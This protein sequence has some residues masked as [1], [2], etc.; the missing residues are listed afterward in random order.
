[1][2][3]NNVSAV[4]SSGELDFGANS[5]LAGFRL[6]RL[7]VLNWGTFDKRVWAFRPDGKNA[8]LTGDI[9]SGKSTLV[10]AV[11]T[12]LV[13]AQRIAYNKAAGADAK[14]RTLRSYVLGYYK[15]ER[16][17]VS[18]NAKPVALRD[19]RSF[20]VI[21]GIFHN[22][23]FDKTV[24]LAQVFWCREPT[25]QPERFYAVAETPLAIADDF[26]H[27]GSSIE[28]LK[29]RLKKAGVALFDS[30]P[31]YSAL[32]RRLLGGLSEQALELFLQT[33]SMKSVGNLTDFVRQHMLEPFDVAPRV[34]ALIAHFDD[35]NRAHAAVL[36][37]QQQVAL[38]TPLVA[39]CDQHAAVL[40][41]ADELRACRDGLRAY[42]S[43]Q[44]LGLIAQRLI[45]LTE[46]LAR[47]SA[48]VSK[49]EDQREQE[50]LQERDLRQALATNGGDRLALLARDI[51]Q[52][53]QEVTR[54]R[55]SAARYDELRRELGLL[56][57]ASTE[58]LVAQQQTCTQMRA[59][60]TAQLDA[61]QNSL[62]ERSVELSEGRRAH[63][64]LSDEITSLK[65]RRSNTDA[66]AVRMRA[67]LCAAL[68][69]DEDSMPFAGEL[70]EVRE[71]QRDWEGAVERL[72]H[73]FGLS[74]LVP[75]ALYAQVA[76]W[77]DQTHLK[78]RLVYFRVR[79]DVRAQAPSLHADS[80]V[81]K[82]VVKPDSPFYAWL[83]REL[84][85]RFDVACCTTQE[86]FRRELRAISRAGQIKSGGERHEKD[87]RHRLDDRSRYVLGWSNTAKLAALNAKRK[88]LE[89]QLAQLGSQIAQ[90]Q[91]Q[92]AQ[93]QERL[94]LLAKLVEYRDYRE[95]D[96][97]T[98][99]AQ[100]AALAQERQ[101]IEAAS[102][103][104][105][106]LTAQL[107]ALEEAQLQTERLSREQRDKR[108][109]VE[110]KI[111][112][113]QALQQQTLETLK[114]E[115]AGA[116]QP[117]LA[118]VEL[119]SP[120]NRRLAQLQADILGAASITLE[121][122]DNRQ[123]D[124]RE[125]LQKLIAAEE[126]KASSLVEKIVDAMRSFRHR[127]PLATQEADASVAASGEFRALLKQLKVDDL[128]RFEAKFKDLLNQNT[129]NQVAQFSA[130][131]AK[132]RET[133]KERLTLINQSL[134]Q[135]DYNPGRFIELQAQLTP[136]AEV[137]DFQSDLRH[138]LDGAI[139]GSAA[140][141]D[142][143]YSE[144]KFLQVKAIIER[145][146]G[147]EGQTD[148]DKR[149]TQ[150]VTD[151]RNWF[152]FAA[153]ERWREDGREHEHYSDSG[154]KSGGQKEKLAYTIL[155]AS[156]AYQFGLVRGEAR[157]KAFRFVVIDEAFGRGSD[158]SAQFGLK[159]FEEL[160]LQLLIVT[161]LQKIHIIEPYVSSVGFVHNDE[162]RDS[163]L[164]NLSIE[165]YRAEQERRAVPMQPSEL[166]MAVAA[167]GG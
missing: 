14:E 103:L 144:A 167:R 163:K 7:E 67:E 61:V 65:A 26:G 152:V 117:D 79:L 101:Q 37:A 76:Q 156:L 143:Q 28:P 29:K 111:A 87:D 138:C 54:R 17:E 15:S 127:F 86:Q 20:S 107:K 128:P 150:K 78:G 30:F 130:Q 69:L 4:A 123:H 82:L 124:L 39:D 166:P 73:N 146:R 140:S 2:T 151:V 96:W 70:I 122:C 40:A 74:L 12:L 19:N 112:Q 80:L 5:A 91:Q 100:A 161:P 106:T 63:A 92:L 153:S 115:L 33:V 48:K 93:C 147:R 94:S 131:L 43:R 129:I 23:G 116:A 42:F 160:N 158:E 141:D 88:V 58:D 13:P 105:Q 22:A 51:A 57:V 55:A 36:K 109:R 10:D 71:D 139:S 164:R 77:V 84:A 136:D 68:N 41:K 27:F 35:L 148:A 62:T 98:P 102:D 125:A 126:R 49:L 114:S 34:A 16:H 81:R 137:R 132:E 56:Q 21:L 121:S 165:Q 113:M 9:G 53:Q 99:A 8:L 83:D 120:L 75:D 25:G 32:L 149:W 3:V 159:L 135:I 157:S 154:G 118:Q 1:M 133:I 31:P 110:E 155:A 38:L 95:L 145:L 89:A 104:L 72:L 6:M 97:A 108:A 66:Q 90:G 46:D 45:N 60:E 52:Q 50:R 18:G 24:T 134:T 59:A 162:G 11:T 64:V 119:S 85:Q 142:G 44:K 47:D